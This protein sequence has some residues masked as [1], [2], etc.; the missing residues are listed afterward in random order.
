MGAAEA[1]VDVLDRLSTAAGRGGKTVDKSWV[2]YEGPRGGEGW[3]NPVTGEVRYQEGKPDG[4]ETSDG[5]KPDPASLDPDKVWADRDNTIQWAY[6]VLPE[7]T[8]DALHD[9]IY[10]DEKTWEQ[11]GGDIYRMAVE[12]VEE[13]GAPK[14]ALREFVDGLKV[15]KT[16]YDTTDED[17]PDP[18]FN[19]NNYE[20]FESIDDHAGIRG[21]QNAPSTFVAHTPDTGEK[22]FVKNL[23]PNAGVPIAIFTHSGIRS[24]RPERAAYASHIVSEVFGLNAVETVHVPGEYLATKEVD[25]ESV[26]SE[27]RMFSPDEPGFWADFMETTAANWLLG[28][29][30]TH[31]RNI[32]LTDEGAVA[33]D[34]DK[35]FTKELAGLEGVFIERVVDTWVD[36]YTDEDARKAEMVVD[37]YL[38]ALEPMANE[39]QDWL[40]E[41]GG[42]GLDEDAV[43]L[44]EKNIHHVQSGAA[45]R[46]LKAELEAY[47]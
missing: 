17:V 29:T 4:S 7:E 22:L 11:T 38:D 47:D 13:T 30:D 5:G 40:N 6:N 25:G 24:Q 12:V 3:A 19:P 2:P 32:F 37:Y 36:P 41:T 35:A 21:G 8:H 44:L 42:G 23:N 27:T 26:W 14:E 9:K 33:V 18:S 46:L 15:S 10:E 34:M 1:L 31:A 16:P 39:A 20:V 43:G 45:R 28:N